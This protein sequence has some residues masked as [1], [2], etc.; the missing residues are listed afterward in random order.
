MAKFKF[1]KTPRCKI[2]SSKLDE[3]GN[4]TWDE[5]PVNMAKRIKE[6]ENEKGGTDEANSDTEATNS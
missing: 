3:Q 6:Q 1:T 5:C 2:C 4:C